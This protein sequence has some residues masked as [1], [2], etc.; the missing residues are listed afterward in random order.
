MRFGNIGQRWVTY[1]SPGVPPS[2]ANGPH[3][4]SKNGPP[5]AVAAADPSMLRRSEMRISSPARSTSPSGQ[6]HVPP[7]VPT[8]P[9]SPVMTRFFDPGCRGLAI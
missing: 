9:M 1:H 5:V 2:H 4:G 8:V 6:V 7:H 3:S